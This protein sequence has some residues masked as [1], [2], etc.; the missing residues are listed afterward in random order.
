MGGRQS[1]LDGCCEPQSTLTIAI[2]P[3]KRMP[4][5]K[6]KQAKRLATTAIAKREESKK[7]LPSPKENGANQPTSFASS[8]HELLNAKEHLV[9][10]VQAH[11]VI[12]SVKTPDLRRV[13]RRQKK[14]DNIQHILI[15]A[16]H[17]RDD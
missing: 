7:E 6:S 12:Q 4:A 5:S 13:F 17:I 15:D 11:K 2:E 3:G 1:L 8:I 14:A 9:E 16:L 10:L